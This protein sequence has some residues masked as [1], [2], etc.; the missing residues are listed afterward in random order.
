MA[1]SLTYF[2]QAHLCVYDKE[3]MRCFLAKHCLA[4]NS[5]KYFTYFWW[6][7]TGALSKGITQHANKIS[8]DLYEVIK[9]KSFCA[10]AATDYLRSPP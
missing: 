4:Y 7:H 8:K 2:L 6:S 5:L 3:S 9:S 10:I 1:A